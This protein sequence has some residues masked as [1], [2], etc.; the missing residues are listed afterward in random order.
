M[1]NKKYNVAIVGATGLVGGTFLKVLAEVKFPI[2][3]LRLLASAK[4]AGKV[5]VYEGK[6]YIVEE[7]NEN[8]FDGMDLALFSAGASVSKIYAP[9]AEAKGC[10][11]ID[12]SSCFR[13][14]TDKALIVPEVNAFDAD[15]ALGFSR[16]IANPNCS[17]IQA[18][19]P[20]KPLAEKYGLKRVVYTTYQA[21]SGSG[22][23]GILDLEKSLKGEKC[24]FYPYN[25]SETCIPEIDVALDNGYTK[26][27]MKMVNETRKMLH[28]P[29]LKVSATCVRV[30]V[31]N[32]HAVSI[33]VELEKQFDVEEVKKLI[34]NYPG[35][36]LV[37]DL[38]NHKYPVSQLSNGNNL[39]YVGRIRRDL[40]CDNGLLLYTVG[41]NI[42]KGAASNA[43]QIAEY[44]DEKGWIK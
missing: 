38:K 9:I 6:E 43:V 18:I 17:T 7:L 14:D 25:I 1:E 33:M 27:E 26:E 22:M 36:A 2:N 5:I 28:L 3:N 10:L 40:S 30:P 41:D 39:V 20:L 11:V 15:P 32:S 24:T 35:L 44:M 29:D 12:N 31:K 23:K 13:N 21:V 34:A 42:R 16:I 19:I 37:D 8:S 4:S